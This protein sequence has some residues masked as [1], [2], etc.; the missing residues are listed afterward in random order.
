V[1]IF[2]V[3]GTL[4][5]QPLLRLRMLLSLVLYYSV[6]FGSL[7]ELKVLKVFRIQREKIA[8]QNENF[9]IDQQYKRCAGLT[10]TAENKVKKIV[11][12]WIH[13][14]PLSYISKYKFKNIDNLLSKMREK[15]IIVCVYSDYFA[16][17]KIKKLRL[18]FD[19]VFSSEQIE[20]NKIKPSP[21][22]LNYIVSK[23][24]AKK[25][26]ALMIGDRKDIDGLC[27]KNAG[28]DFLKV[29]SFTANKIFKQ[30]GKKL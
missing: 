18:T 29:N 7:N 13:N 8:F 24:G 11:Q 21:D 6:H 16:D 30:L 23:L 20:I 15:G 14:I 19:H 4:Y 9:P 2:D 17:D 10:N 1:V 26:K 5:N 28:I 25:E 12:K 22:G 3:D 27:A